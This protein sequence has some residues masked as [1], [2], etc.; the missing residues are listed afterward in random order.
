MKLTPSEQIM[1]NVLH[2]T[3]LDNQD[4]AL[5]TA[6][7]F[8]FG[9]LHNQST[10]FPCLVTNRHVLSR[11]AKIR[12]CFTRKKEDGS[13]DIGKLFEVTVTTAGAIYHPDNAID[14]AILPIGSVLNKLHS[15]NK[16]VFFIMFEKENIPKPEEWQD[17]SAIEN[18]VMAGF[19]KGLRDEVNNQPIIRSGATATH[20]ALEYQG[21][22]YFLV[23]MPCFEGCSG[24]PIL[25]CSEGMHVN[26]R[27]NSVSSGSFVKLLG[28]QFA[29]PSKYV[30]GQLA[31][32]QTVEAK[33]VPVVQLYMNLGFI[34][35]S[36]E[37]LV[38]EDILSAKLN[39]STG[40][41]LPA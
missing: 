3:M 8:L 23:D 1:Y 28:V 40:K 24:S 4:K 15:T 35:K 18:V 26:R 36:T 25:I 7:G 17:F 10:S 31:Q 33:D 21:K 37:L 13:A 14:L 22:P 20:P 2:I 27:R 16:D 38:F 11:C 32:I 34:I 6:T 29:I 12:L 5:G 19:P 39:S 9:F 30:I 41:E